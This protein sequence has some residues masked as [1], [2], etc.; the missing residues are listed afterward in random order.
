MVSQVLANLLSNAIKYSLPSGQPKIVIDAIDNETDI[1]Y[2]IK[3][4]GVGIDIKQLPRVFELFKR[5]DNVQD[6]EGTGVGLAI[7]K[8][9]VEK[10]NGKIWVDSKINGG[11]TF[12]VS[13]KK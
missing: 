11:S 10:H 6:I 9:I 2:T 1:T 5:M 13:F 4:N 7:V 8:R 12:F 3:D